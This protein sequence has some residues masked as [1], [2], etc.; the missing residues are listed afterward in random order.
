MKKIKAFV[1]II[2]LKIINIENLK[3]IFIFVNIIGENNVK[4]KNSLVQHEIRCKEK[5]R[6]IIYQ[7][8]NFN[9]FG[10]IPWNKGLTKETD[11]RLKTQGE[12]FKQ[13]Y[14]DG[15]IKIWSDGLNKETDERIKNSS[16]KNSKYH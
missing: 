10:R 9:N 4:T 14:K 5:S 11:E 12:T 16:I 2:Y 3:K 8:N 15:K 7:Y 13:K 6:P 1:Q